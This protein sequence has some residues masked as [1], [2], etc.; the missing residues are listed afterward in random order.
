MCPQ[1]KEG[2][3]CPE[4]LAFVDILLSIKLMHHAI[5]AVESSG[6]T[7]PGPVSSGAF[8]RSGTLPG[9]VVAATQPMMPKDTIE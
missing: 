7:N 9:I 2:S 5:G 1:R 6:R 3:N 4:R 8:A